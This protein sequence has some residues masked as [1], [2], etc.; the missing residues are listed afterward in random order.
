MRR[1]LQRF[2]EYAEGKSPAF[3]AEAGLKVQ[4][5]SLSNIPAEA[6]G[7]EMERLPAEM[8]TF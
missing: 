7:A 8:S 6:A 2:V 1:S 4:R 3:R 5:P